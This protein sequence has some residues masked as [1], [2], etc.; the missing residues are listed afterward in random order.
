LV[1]FYKQ[2]KNKK[3]NDIIYI[4]PHKNILIYTIKGDFKEM[5]CVPILTS[6]R[7]EVVTALNKAWSEL[8]V[9]EWEA[10]QAQ[11]NAKMDSDKAMISFPLLIKL[12]NETSFRYYLQIHTVYGFVGK[13]ICIYVCI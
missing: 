3:L 5:L 9:N 8:A 4:I 1:S 11:Q 10:V 7:Q 13:Y 12:L 2:Q 6:H